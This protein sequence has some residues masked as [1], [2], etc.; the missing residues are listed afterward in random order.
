MF[1][2]IGGICFEN[3]NWV[4]LDKY[5]LEFPAQKLDVCFDSDGY[6]L[7]HRAIMGGNIIATQYLVNKGMNTSKTSL[8]G[9]S[10]LYISVTKAPSESKQTSNFCA[11]YSNRYL[12]KNSILQYTHCAFLS[13][14]IIL[15]RGLKPHLQFNA[16]SVV[17][18]NSAILRRSIFAV[19]LDFKHNFHLTDHEA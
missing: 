8:S 10:P 1:E 18:M 17:K 12:S 15:W 4:F 3:Q 7:L 5:L 19:C 16:F 9:L 14:N 13:L 11:G 6:N 2:N